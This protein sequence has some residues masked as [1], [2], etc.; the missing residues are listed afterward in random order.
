MADDGAADAAIDEVFA[1]AATELLERADEY[2]ERVSAR[3]HGEI[4]EFP[5]PAA[6]TPQTRA[7][8]RSTLLSFLEMVRSPK[9][10][11]ATHAPPEAVGYARAFVHRRVPVRI[12]LRTYVLGYGELW[13]AWTGAIRSRGLTPELELRAFEA[14]AEVMFRFMDGLTTEI[15][16]VFEAEQARWSRSMTAI[17]AELVESILAERP[18]DVA[19]AER[20]LVYRLGD[21][22][23]GVAIS[24]FEDAESIH[25]DR[26]DQTW[27]QLAQHAGAGRSLFVY[28][29]RRVMW[30]WFGG[31]LERM[32]ALV[33]AV[34]G[35]E[36]P[37][38]GVGVAVGEAAEG[39]AGFRDSHVQALHAR[40]VA[41]LGGR[42]P[43]RVARFKKLAVPALT[44]IDPSLSAFFV[45]HQLGALADDSDSAARLRA[46]LET[47]F[48]E[49]ESATATGRR[50]GIHANT[51]SYRM[52]QIEQIVGYPVETQRLELQL[53]LRL[54]RYVGAAERPPPVQ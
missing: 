22:H 50:L 38:P 36:I 37:V 15:V 20:T 49:G 9:R 1:T 54:I 4:D 13:R 26:L 34:E 35:W 43:R 23:V 29:G 47:F 2:G 44:S 53:A 46:T 14:S 32:R 27:Q 17:R 30:G 25:Q 48:E 51:V 5:F 28:A 8:V 33:D 11:G 39:L 42:S 16:E 52:R 18:V 24:T 19:D 21:A 40:R 12:L 31:S 6:V 7:A 41:G 3:V 10:S 45:R